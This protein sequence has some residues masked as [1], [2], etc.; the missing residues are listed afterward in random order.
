[1]ALPQLFSTNVA[2]ESRPRDTEIDLF[3]LTHPGLVRRDNQDHF[4]LCTLHRQLVV[5]ASSM[6]NVDAMPLRGERLATIAMVADGVGGAAAGEEASRRALEAIAHYVSNTMQV[7]QHADTHDEDAF[8]TELRAA[9]EEAHVAVQQAAELAGQG[10]MATTLT[11]LISLWP[12]AYIVQVGDSRCYYCYDGTLQRMTRDQT[13]A[14]DLIDAGALQADEANRSPYSHVLYSALGADAPTP[15]VTAM[16]VKRGCAAL[17]CSDGLNRHVTDDE[18][19]HA[20]S[21]GAASEQVCRELLQLALDRGGEDN[22][23]ILVAQAPH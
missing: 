2:A 22:I 18:I 19:Q 9:V 23:T 20:L 8:S 14:Q 7:V 21:H 3:G 1:M 4:L 16:M 5:H 6:P 17:L 10:T 12:Q 11:L 15:V 13:V